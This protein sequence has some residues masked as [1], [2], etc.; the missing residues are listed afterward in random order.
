M[1]EADMCVAVIG[2]MDRLKKH[3]LEEAKKVGVQLKVFTKL[4]KDTAKKIG[5]VDAIVIF[6]NKVSHELKLTIKK[7]YPNKKCP[8][9]MCHSCGVS[10]LIKCLENLQK[11]KQKGGM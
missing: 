5:E 1:L 8:H 6:T 10:S 11:M 9:L 7:A 3:Y 4:E 2:G